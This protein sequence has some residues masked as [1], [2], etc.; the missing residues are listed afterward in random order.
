MD[1][2]GSSF[3]PSNSSQLSQARPTYTL[4]QVPDQAL[5]LDNSTVSTI[6]SVLLDIRTELANLKA[7][8]DQI[9]QSIA[10]NPSIV[11]GLRRTVATCPAVAPSVGVDPILF[12]DHP[13]F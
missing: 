9:Q 10:P 12:L 4:E 1:D 5:E 6:F 11:A 8:V 2:S 13:Y 7:S 3:H